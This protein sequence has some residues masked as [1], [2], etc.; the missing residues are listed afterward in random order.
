MIAAATR[1]WFEQ[2]GTL[3][4]AAWVDGRFVDEVVFGLLAPDMKST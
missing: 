2:E 1:V 4:G 3:H